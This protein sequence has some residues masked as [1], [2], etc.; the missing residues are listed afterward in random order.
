MAAGGLVI[1]ATTISFVRNRILDSAG[2]RLMGQAWLA[3]A[4]DFFG[5]PL[6]ISS[7]PARSTKFFAK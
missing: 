7:S 5:Q 3:M 1:C 6:T 2:S 4:E